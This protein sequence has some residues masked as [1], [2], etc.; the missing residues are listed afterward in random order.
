M[1]QNATTRPIF[2]FIPLVVLSALLIFGVVGIG[3]A[4]DNAVFS[5]QDSAALIEQEGN[6]VTVRGTITR[7][8][9]TDDGSVTFLNFGPRA[10]DQFVVVVFSRD[11]QKFPEGFGHLT[12]QT[13]EVTGTLE[14]FRNQQPQIRLETPEQISVVEN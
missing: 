1:Q 3:V 7:V 9:A 2:H 13:V 14:M 11:L 5:A 10:A 4:E 12:G 8:G 6:V